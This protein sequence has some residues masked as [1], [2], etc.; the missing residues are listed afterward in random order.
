MPISETLSTVK[1]TV[2]WIRTSGL[3][4]DVGVAGV[5]AGILLGALD[6]GLTAAVATGAGAGFL[7]LCTGLMP[8]RD[9]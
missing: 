4:G 2:Q 5:V 9:E 7:T 1:E 6:W 3:S 8:D